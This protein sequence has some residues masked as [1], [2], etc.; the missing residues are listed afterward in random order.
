[1]ALFEYDGLYHR[2]VRQ[3][4]FAT[5]GSGSTIAQVSLFQRGQSADCDL[6]TT[7]YTV[8]E[9]EKDARAAPGVGEEFEMAVLRRKDGECDLQ[10]L[11]EEAD[12]RLGVLY[13]KLE[14]GFVP[15]KIV[16]PENPFSTERW[17]GTVLRA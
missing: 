15:D 11:T 8:Y 2:L 3:L 13:A 7:L 12:N 5:V 17:L 4:D 9:A 10:W 1:M 16:L 14:R 6:N